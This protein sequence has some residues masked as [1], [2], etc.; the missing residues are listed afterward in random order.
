[1]LLKPSKIVHGESISI[2]DLKNKYLSDKEGIFGVNA[3]AVDYKNNP[4]LYKQWFKFLNEQDL[5]MTSV[6]TIS[7]IIESYLESIEKP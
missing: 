3:H 7:R 6:L 1:M 2:D 4:N 5:R